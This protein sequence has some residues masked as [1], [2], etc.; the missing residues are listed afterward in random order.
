MFLL[1]V[2]QLKIEFA[3]EYTLWGDSKLLN[4]NGTI[5]SSTA[6]CYIVVTLL[7]CSKGGKSESTLHCFSSCNEVGQVLTMNTQATWVFMVIAL[8]GWS[9]PIFVRRI[10]FF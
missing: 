6:P 2:V 3:F 4:H 7:V 1:Q 8:I 10:R 5:D 9:L